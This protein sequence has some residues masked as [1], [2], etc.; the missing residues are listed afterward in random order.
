MFIVKNSKKVVLKSEDWD[1]ALKTFVEE[2]SSSC[3]LEDTQSVDYV[4]G[5]FVDQHGR[6]QWGQVSITKK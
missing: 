6:F 2:V 1:R 5:M 4:V 3:S